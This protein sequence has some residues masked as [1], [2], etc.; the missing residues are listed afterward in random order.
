MFPEENT[1][2]SIDGKD[3]KLDGLGFAW[4][5]EGVDESGEDSAA[6]I[7]RSHIEKEPPRAGCATWMVRGR[8]S[9]GQATK[10]VFDELFERY[11]E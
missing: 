10:K 3:N 8:A 2:N 5:G 1:P 9:E 6:Q 4:K 7:P 11:P